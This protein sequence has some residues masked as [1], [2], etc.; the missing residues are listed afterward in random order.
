MRRALPALMLLL[1]A[2]SNE[3]LNPIVGAAVQELNPFDE[4][5][6][7]AAPVA[8][9]PVTRAAINRADVAMIRIRL[10]EEETPAYMF[11]AS[12]N[13]GFVTY[14]SSLR[15]LVTLRG[16]QVTATRGLGYDLLSVRSSQPDPLTRPIP[17]G[18]WPAQVTRSFEFPADAPRGRVETFE[19]RYEFGAPSEIVIVEDRHQGVQISEYCSGP[20][21]EFENLHFADLRTGFVWRSI[22][23]LGPQQGLLDVEIVH[24]YTGRRG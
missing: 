3:G 15:Q 8:A 14:A 17:P 5:A 21:G 20:T 18:Q 2:C 6:P 19:C 7:E 12:D 9:A 16:S 11:A 10:V 22:Q 4:D 24:P 13:G 1:A 23:W